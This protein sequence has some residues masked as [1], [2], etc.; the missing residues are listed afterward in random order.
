MYLTSYKAM[1]FIKKTQQ[2]IKYLFNVAVIGFATLTLGGPTASAAPPKETSGLSTFSKAELL[3]QSRWS[4]VT[5]GFYTNLGWTDVKD[6]AYTG[7]AGFFFQGAAFVWLINS[8]GISIMLSVKNNFSE[9]AELSPASLANKLVGSLAGSLPIL[10]LFFLIGVVS[11]TY[12]LVANKPENLVRRFIV[13]IFLTVTLFGVVNQSNQAAEDN[14]NTALYTLSAGNIFSKITG[15]RDMISNNIAIGLTPSPS[16]YSQDDA[17]SCVAIASRLESAYAA[18]STSVDDGI[19]LQSSILWKASYLQLWSAAQLGPGTSGDRSS[20]YLF[21]DWLGTSEED[22]KILWP[23]GSARVPTSNDDW[24]LLWTQDDS[25]QGRRE[26][27]ALFAAC[28]WNANTQ[29]Y[30]INDDWNFIGYTMENGQWVKPDDNWVTGDDDAGQPTHERC[31]A[32][33]TDGKPN[34]HGFKMTSDDY[35]NLTKHPN[36]RNASIFLSSRDGHYAESKVTQ[37]ILALVLASIMTGINILFTLSIV[38]ADFFAAFTLFLWVII[39][40]ISLTGSESSK[41]RLKAW[42][43][44]TITMMMFAGT[45]R[46]GFAIWTMILSW[47]MELALNVQNV[48]MNNSISSVF[49][50]FATGSMSYQIIIFCIMCTMIFGI[51][52]LARKAI[53]S[54][55]AGGMFASAMMP[56]GGLKASMGGFDNMSNAM[57]GK[58]GGGREGL[59]RKGYRAVE[60]LNRLTDSNTATGKALQRF[61]ITDKVLDKLN[62]NRDVGDKSRAERRKKSTALPSAMRSNKKLSDAEKTEVEARRQENRFDVDEAETNLAASEKG[63]GAALGRVR[64]FNQLSLA[65]KNELAAQDIASK[66]RAMLLDPKQRELAGAQ[67]EREQ[68]L[69]DPKRLEQINAQLDSG[70][71]TDKDKEALLL[72]QKSISD[73]LADNGEDATASQAMRAELMSVDE[74]L[75]NS[76][77]DGLSDEQVSVL[78]NRRNALQSGLVAGSDAKRQAAA[79]AAEEKIKVIENELNDLE[80]TS[81]EIEQTRRRHL[82]ENPTDA[83]TAAMHESLRVRE[84]GLNS[85]LEAARQARDHHEDLAEIATQRAVAYKANAAQALAID[86]RLEDAEARLVTAKRRSENSETLSQFERSIV[87]SDRNTAQRD[88][89]SAR[90]ELAKLGGSSKHYMDKTRRDMTLPSG[91]S[92]EW[93]VGKHRLDPPAEYTYEKK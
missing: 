81:L 49:S 82:L 28:E 60:G 86:K 40:I 75:A 85:Q 33:W 73:R 83:D 87:E 17:G 34:E 5:N 30:D 31:K 92:I 8:I 21:E 47:G 23:S 90:L 44:Q 14:K 55:G 50:N 25:G 1:K 53:K 26:A 54:G 16:G 89:A 77:D 20:C 88:L 72:E 80:A 66:E 63:L 38:I 39:A 6:K 71:L 11:I 19:A 46:I 10:I 36:S 67:A 4:G 51:L 22:L 18:K 93:R 45:A 9:N 27:L 52:M 32:A 70:N 79:I 48:L 56:L 35:K 76:K 2:K 37:G 91:D 42:S 15:L 13:L 62:P 78:R 59:F 3:P 12:K 7:I 69:S 74:Q 43:K 64:G 29:I 41:Q 61:G 65:E 57:H 58:G 84:A 68:Y 24:L